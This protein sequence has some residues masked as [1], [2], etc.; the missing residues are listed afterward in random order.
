MLYVIRV[1]VCENPRSGLP[2]YF[3]N[4]FYQACG[5]RTPPPSV[6][7]W[8]RACISR[9]LWVMGKLGYGE[10]E[11]RR[12]F[13]LTLIDNGAVYFT[14]RSNNVNYGPYQLLL[15]FSV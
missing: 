1:R 10:T 7:A 5:I 6:K 11:V 2:H 8:V 13:S 3:V 15:P 4:G 12:G 9:M 14:E